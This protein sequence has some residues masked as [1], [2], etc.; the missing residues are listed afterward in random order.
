[1]EGARRLLISENATQAEIKIEHKHSGF[2]IPGKSDMRIN[3]R[4]LMDAV[5]EDLVRIKELHGIR[6]A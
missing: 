3:I 6:S 5:Q 2:K 4:K 1:M